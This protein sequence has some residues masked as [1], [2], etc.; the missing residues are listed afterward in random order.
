[1]ACPLYTFALQLHPKEKKQAL[2][3]LVLVYC[4][5][6]ESTTSPVTSINFQ[7]F[8]TESEAQGSRFPGEYF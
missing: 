6:T 2:I 5:V 7:A 3:L 8:R 4:T 1:M